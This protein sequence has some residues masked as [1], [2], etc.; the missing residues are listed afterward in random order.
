M[1]EN[2]GGSM[3]R[4]AM[5]EYM[6]WY[7]QPAER[8]L[9]GLPI[10]N[11]T[12]GA[13]VMGG[14]SD[15]RLALNHECLWR[16][17]SRHRT[18]EKKSHH[19]PEIRKKFFEGDLKEAGEYANKILCGPEH[20]VQ[21]YQPVGDLNVHLEGYDDV[22]DYK[23][24]LDMSEG[25]AFVEYSVDGVKYRREVFA[26]YVHKV[27]VVRMTCDKQGCLNGNIGLERIVDEECKLE[28]W[29][30]DASLGFSAEFAEGV[31]FACEARVI[32][33][34]GKQSP[35]AD[36]IIGFDAADD[37]LVILAMATTVESEDPSSGCKAILDNVPFDYH[38]L[39]TEHIRDHSQLFGKVSLDLGVGRSDLPTDLRLA[40]MKTG[41]DDLGLMSLYFNFGRYLLISSSRP[42]SLP[43]N[44]QGIW[45]E[46]LKPPWDSDFH[47]DLNLQ[48]N[49]WPAEACNLSECT[50]PFF[51]FFDKMIPEAKKAAID[52][53]DSKGIYI[54]ITT[55]VWAKCTPEAPGWDVW[56]GAGAW[57]ANH[58]WQHY[59]YTLDRDFLRKRAYP[60]M[61]QIAEFYEGYLIEDSKGRLV[62]VP[63][64]SPE[65][66]FV[67]GRE[68]VSLCIS[69]TMDIEL[70]HDVLTHVIEAS[71][72]L[73]LDEDDIPKWQNILDRI[74]PLQIGKYGQLQEWLED[75]DEVE[76]GHRHLSHLVG[77]FP[78]D[79][80]TVEVTPELAQAVRAVLERREKHTGGYCGWTHAWMA[81]CWARFGEGDRS[82][83]HLRPLLTDFTA[84][85][86]FDLIFGDCFQIDGNFGGTA[87][88][89]EM[90]LQSH[91]G[92]IRIL[93]ALPEVWDYGSVKGLV[94]R[95]GFEIEMEW[96]QNSL[97]KLTLTS[98][99]GNEAHVRIYTSGK[100][101]IMCD[102]SVVKHTACDQKYVFPTVAGKSYEFVRQ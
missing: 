44:L 73:K 92:V 53:Y 12:I 11:G 77:W 70:I 22:S 71:R 48:M 79:Q 3:E 18:T 41:G 24:G 62:T 2:G 59:E 46:M 26:S 90:L 27:I 34:N 16:G 29:S 61:R 31:G 32:C 42:G 17:K 7:K 75:Y 57:L 97:E 33:E 60:F 69:A 89:T 6:L 99:L 14:I 52:L 47:L 65:N 30:N 40:E 95:G 15:E 87:A 86:L 8:W 43:G 51:D 37:V 88:V 96:K 67:G 78:G 56:T 100:F 5:N 72:I 80:I 102:G 55:D 98:H 9:D 84:I 76:P 21:P 45:N 36:G 28:K 81:C 10:G 49:Y 93:P 25:I 91:N 20:A 4:I 35:K 63:S 82:W 83:R 1:G 23:R 39:K 50:Q 74:P 85:S 66:R 68:P 13:M 54:P 19:L 38:T 101:S 58:Y 64:Q 94:A